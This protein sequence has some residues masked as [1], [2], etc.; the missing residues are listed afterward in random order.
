MLDRGVSPSPHSNSETLAQRLHE[1]RCRMRG[2]PDDLVE[3]QADLHE[4][5]VVQ[6]NVER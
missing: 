3:G 1:C 2:T 6:G 4:G 5:D